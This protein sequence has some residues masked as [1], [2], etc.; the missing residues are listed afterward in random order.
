MRFTRFG[1]TQ[2]TAA[3]LV[4]MA[5][6]SALA[7]PPSNDVFNGATSATVPFRDVLDTTEATTD[8]DD[9]QLN[10]TCHG[11]ALPFAHT[12]ASV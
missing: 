3:L 12:D 2:W 5:S 4:W 11:G 10:A 8:G 9:A 1:I 7:A 6:G